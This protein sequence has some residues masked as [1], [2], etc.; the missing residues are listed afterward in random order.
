[1]ASWPIASSSGATLEP[2]EGDCPPSRIYGPHVDLNTLCCPRSFILD[3]E[4]E[5]VDW[6]F[7]SLGLRISRKLPR[8]IAMDHVGIWRLQEQSHCEFGASPPPHNIFFEKSGKDGKE[9]Q[10]RRDV[11]S[12]PLAHG[13]EVCHELLDPLDGV[14]DVQDAP[15]ILEGL[16]C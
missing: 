7:P 12:D 13:N 10:D 4:P 9:G 2:L 6:A 8:H 16:N 15:T 14:K 1:M 3:P 5:I 11:F